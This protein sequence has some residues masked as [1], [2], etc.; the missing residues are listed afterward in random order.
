VHSRYERRLLDT[1]IAGREMLLCVRVRRMFCVNPDCARKTSVEQVPGLAARRARRTEVLERLLRGVA[2]ALVGRPGARLTQ[3]LAAAVSRMTLLRMLRALPEPALRTP[4][5][6]GVDDF[7]LRRGHHYGTI[8]IDIESRRPVEVLPD[9]TAE[10]HSAWLQV[11]PG[12]QI[13]CRDRV[14][15]YA[16]GARAGAPQALQV[17]DRWHVYNNLA[18]AVERTV[19][20]HRSSLA[21]AVKTSADSHADDTE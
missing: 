18:A 12:V 3:R 7:T 4:R 16:D 6:L 10:T 11:H 21:A 8:L 5:V 1:V 20:R 2:L 17:A 9:R 15:A 13:V 19:A 14:G